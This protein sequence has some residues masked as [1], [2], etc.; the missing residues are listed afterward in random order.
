[1]TSIKA[2]GIAGQQSAHNGSNGNIAGPQKQM[3]M[4]VQ[5]C[6][7]VTKRFTAAD[8]KRKSIH[9]IIPVNITYKNLST[10]NT[11][12]NDMLQ[13][14]G[15]I[16]SCLSWHFLCVSPLL[17]NGNA[18]FHARPQNPSRHRIALGRTLFALPCS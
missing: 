7:C 17:E 5:Q 15:G 2:D 3:E 1:M 13:R 11:S 18:L 10:F 14:S 9:K 4:I 12:A 6:P 8:N 16:Y